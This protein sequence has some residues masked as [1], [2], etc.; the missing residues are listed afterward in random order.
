M[1]YVP[2]AA[3]VDRIGA[4][5]RAFCDLLRATECQP[6]DMSALL[7]QF[8]QLIADCETCIMNGTISHDALMMLKSTAQRIQIVSG[9]LATSEDTIKRIEQ[10]MVHQI[11]DTLSSGVA[12]PELSEEGNS[13]DPAGQSVH[14]LRHWFLS[15]F[16]YPYPDDTARDSLVRQVPSMT[17]TQVGTWFIN[18]RRRSG[19]SAFRRE[20]ANDDVETFQ[21]LLETIDEP[22]NEEAKKRYDKVRLYFEPDR[23]EAASETILEVIK[24]GP[25]KALPPKEFPSR[26]AKR[27]MKRATRGIYPR[28]DDEHLDAIPV[29]NSGL[30]LRRTELPLAASSSSSSPPPSFNPHIDFPSNLTPT[31][32]GLGEA[33][34]PSVFSSPTTPTRSFSDASSSSLDSIVSYGSYD[35]ARRVVRM[36]ARGPFEEGPANPAPQQQSL[37]TFP[38]PSSQ[39]LA[40]PALGVEH[41]HA[42]P[43]ASFAP[44][45]PHPYFCTVNELPTAPTVGGLANLGL[46]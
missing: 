11:R 39:T 40:L 27:V 12:T 24:Q 3:L 15:N 5:D 32:A 6:V 2:K 42:G 17:R 26:A 20:F 34:Y 21:H 29:Q 19:W 10:D 38:S 43:S 22:G 9:P 46:R 8:Q 14:P 45:R 13:D 28:H 1:T 37:D 44:T 18:A 23:K 30:P 33:R 41:S 25:P 4:L 31:P 35:F 36:D 7:L 16:D